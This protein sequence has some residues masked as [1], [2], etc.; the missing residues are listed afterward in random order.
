MLVC[1]SVTNETPATLFQ[2]QWRITHRSADGH[3]K[4]AQVVDPSVDNRDFKRWHDG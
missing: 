1:V 2:L 3:R 4:Q